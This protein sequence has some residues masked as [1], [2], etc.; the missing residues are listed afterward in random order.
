MAPIYPV[1]AMKGEITMQTTDILQEKTK[2][3][4]IPT[5]IAHIDSRIDPRPSV[6]T[7]LII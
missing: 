3:I 2:P 1:K 6:D 5:M 7:P 4:V